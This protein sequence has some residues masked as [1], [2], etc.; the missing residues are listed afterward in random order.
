[1]NP[2]RNPDE[3]CICGHTYE[4][5]FGH[6][7]SRLFLDGSPCP[8]KQFVLGGLAVEIFEALKKISA[9][10]VGYGETF[11]G[12]AEMGARPVCRECQQKI[13]IAQAVIRKAGAEEMQF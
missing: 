8:C 4:V 6:E 5:H 13:E 10:P 1:M 2:R 11:N 12:S 7:C 3:I 9:H